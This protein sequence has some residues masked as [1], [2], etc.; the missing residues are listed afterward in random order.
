MQKTGEKNRETELFLF[1]YLYESTIQHDERA[2]G[3]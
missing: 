3:N 2:K 1:L